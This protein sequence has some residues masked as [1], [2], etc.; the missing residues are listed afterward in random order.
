MKHA[1]KGKQLNLNIGTRRAL[2]KNLTLSL[3]QSGQIVTTEAKAK[4]VRASVEKLITKAKKGTVQ[5]RR[6]INQVLNRR[7]AVNQL[8][9]VIAPKI[10]RTSGFT[11]ITKM[12]SRR[13][14]DAKMARLEI[15]D[16]KA[17][18]AVKAI[19]KDEKTVAKKEDKAVAAKPV[20]KTEEKMVS[21]VKRPTAAT[22]QVKHIPQK[23]IAGGGK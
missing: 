21:K 7:S 14:D 3:I 19:T 4:A 10:E 6:L 9:D 18:V 2:F 8:V 17:E 11:R 15:I 22:S 16:W 12:V 20:A 23:R 5:S 1:V 13:G